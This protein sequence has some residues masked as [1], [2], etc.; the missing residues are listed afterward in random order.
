MPPEITDVRE[1]KRYEA[2]GVGAAKEDARAIAQWSPGEN[3]WSNEPACLEWEDR[4]RATLDDF[5]NHEGDTRRYR[6]EKSELWIG[7][8]IVGDL[9]F[10]ASRDLGAVSAGL[11][12]GSGG[13]FRRARPRTRI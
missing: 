13:I 5:A 7:P 1:L 4:N 2:A 6:E 8:S 10:G 9:A 3:P 12:P 11:R